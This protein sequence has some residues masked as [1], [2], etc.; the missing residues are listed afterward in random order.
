MSEERHECQTMEKSFILLPSIRAKR[1]EGVG[2]GYEL[3]SKLSEAWQDAHTM[4][5]AS[6]LV[7]KGVWVWEGSSA[8]R[9]RG[10]YSP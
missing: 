8:C 10:S 7:I 5:A 2:S 6:S 3:R 9:R 4:Y 1:D